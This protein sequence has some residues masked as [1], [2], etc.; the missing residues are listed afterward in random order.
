MGKRRLPGVTD[1]GGRML[2]TEC[3]EPVMPRHLVL[4]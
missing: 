4:A 1:K 2:L 3:S